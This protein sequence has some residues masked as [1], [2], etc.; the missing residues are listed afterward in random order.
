MQVAQA[1]GT[2]TLQRYGIEWLKEALDWAPLYTY[3]QHI[4]Y[5]DNSAMV[6]SGS[7]RPLIGPH[8]TERHYLS[9]SAM[10]MSGSRRPLMGP[11][12]PRDTNLS[13]SAMVLRGSRR[14]PIGPHYTERHVSGNT[15]TFQNSK[16]TLSVC[17]SKS[18]R[19]W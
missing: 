19:K 14:P 5:T 1:A 3:I 8:Y 18:I 13:D 4:D 11:I 16:R 12:T 6:L 9:D 2:Y 7:R 10:V 15:R 17:C